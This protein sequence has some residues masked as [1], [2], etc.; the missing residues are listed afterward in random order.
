MPNYSDTRKIDPSQENKLGDGT[1]NDGDR[2]EIG[3]TAL[4]LPNG[5]MQ[6][7]NYLI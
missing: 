6:V 5:V 4:A 1:P 2:I 3:Q 7:W